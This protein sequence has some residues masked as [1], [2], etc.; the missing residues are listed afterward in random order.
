MRERRAGFT[1]LEVLLALAILSAL[2][3]AA[4]T[5][6]FSTVAARD[7][8]QAVSDATS[9]AQSLTW[10]LREELRGTVVS[11]ETSGAFVGQAGLQSG[12]DLL[13]FVTLSNPLSTRQGGGLFLV[14][15]RLEQNAA[16][17]ALV[18][19]LRAQTL[20]PLDGSV[21]EQFEPV[22]RRL[23]SCRLEYFDGTIW[24]EEWAQE[25]APNAARVLVELP[26][27]EQGAPERVTATIW[28]PAAMNQNQNQEAGGGE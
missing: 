28:I 2:L 16:D 12:G 8:V 4:Y 3:A 27:M 14:S 19:L 15:Y 20:W 5:M 22:F 24:A 6:L 13:S 26:A 10:L 18:D 25:N 21:T 7:H 23:R 17:P 9:S 1:L 11:S